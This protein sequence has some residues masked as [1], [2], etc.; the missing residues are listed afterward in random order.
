MAEEKP[1]GSHAAIVWGAFILFIGVVLL[2]QVTGVLEWRIWGTLWKFWPVLIIV[3][4]LSFLLRRRHGWLMA[5]LTLTIFGA[6][7]WISALQ[8]VPNLSHDIT[9]VEQ[10]FTYPV[11]GVER[12]EARIEFAAGSLVLTE[13]QT[14]HQLLCEINDGRDSQ[15]K[16]EKRIL[17]M[18]A[19]F[20]EENGTVSIDVKPVNQR[21]WDDWLIHWRLSFNPQVPIVLDVSCDGSRVGLDLEDLDIVKLYLEMDVC[22]GL[23]T[24]PTSAGQTIIDIDMDVSNLEIT[25]P[26]GVAVKI[27][28]DINLSIF[29]IDTE[30]FLRQGDYF[31]SPD[32]ASAT[33]RI[34]LNILCDVSRLTIK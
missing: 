29:K 19:D 25:V 15:N 34:E 6:C 31:I 11:I 21:V 16:P 22:S 12:A 5:L 3:V 10:R 23:L 9:L 33:N 17:T 27:K 30:R 14:D 7:L 32:Y 8:Y 26:E 2:L 1:R 18:E 4:G 24:L 13:L 20:A 28:A